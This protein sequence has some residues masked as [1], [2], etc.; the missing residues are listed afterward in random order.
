MTTVTIQ[1]AQARLPDLIHQLPPGEEVVITENSEPVAKLAR[2]D[3]VGWQLFPVHLEHLNP[4][5]LDLSMFAAL[6]VRLG[7]PTLFFRGKIRAPFVGGYLGLAL[8]SFEAIDLIAEPLN[9]GCLLGNGALL[10]G[11]YV[12]QIHE[13]LTQIFLF[14][15]AG[16]QFLGA[17][18]QLFSHAATLHLPFCCVEGCCLITSTFGHTA[19]TIPA[20]SPTI[21]AQCYP[22]ILR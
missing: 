20:L 12:H 6:V 11:D 14:D 10:L 7:L 13:L 8:F 21:P 15:G 3:R 1:E 17:P 2:T 9:F 4:I 22:E 19:L 18:G 5:D 16:V